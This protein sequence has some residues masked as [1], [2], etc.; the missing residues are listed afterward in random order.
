[1]SES[2]SQES[3]TTIQQRFVVTTLEGGIGRVDLFPK[4]QY[5]RA[6]LEAAY[7][8]HAEALV[9]ETPDLYMQVVGPNANLV[10]INSEEAKNLFSNAAENGEFTL[11]IF[12]LKKSTVHYIL[13][14]ELASNVSVDD[15][16]GNDG[17][18]YHHY[19]SSPCQQD[20]SSL[21]SDEDHPDYGGRPSSDDNLGG[22]DDYGGL[23]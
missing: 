3:V 11:Q 18:Y 5:S 10:C 8:T 23:W 16:A 15:N 13:K 22:R 2:N 20:Q 14:F 12:D 9:Q 17:G 4:Q 6:D 19:S 21:F 1:M 7:K